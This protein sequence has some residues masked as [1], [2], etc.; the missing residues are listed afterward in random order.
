M[1]YFSDL[2]D[3]QF[4]KYRIY[5]NISTIHLFYWGD[6]KLITLLKDL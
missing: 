4:Y 2:K 1:Q 5:F 3:I 6:L